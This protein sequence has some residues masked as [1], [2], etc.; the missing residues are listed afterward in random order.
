MGKN[1][2]PHTGITLGAVESLLG[3]LDF[4][5]SLSSEG[6]TRKL[7]NVLS[8][9]L[10]EKAVNAGLVQRYARSGAGLIRSVA[11]ITVVYIE[12]R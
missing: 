7:R 1:Q 12:Y 6:E 11:A 3:A 4:S 5:A 8:V 2:L 10:D 9:R